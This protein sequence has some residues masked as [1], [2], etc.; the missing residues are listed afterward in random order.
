MAGHNHSKEIVQ[1]I[2]SVV[3]I[4]LD[5]DEQVRVVRV[6]V[7]WLITCAW[8]VCV[9]RVR[10]CASCTSYG[11]DGVEGVRGGVRREC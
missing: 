6:C 9:E 2:K 5:D 4:D 1:Q 8:M 3:V 7:T 10:R 11:V